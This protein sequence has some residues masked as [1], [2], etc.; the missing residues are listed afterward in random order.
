[1]I[2]S[3]QSLGRSSE[4]HARQYLQQHGLTYVARNYTTATGEIDLI[5]RDGSVL[6]FIEV[7]TRQNKYFGTAQ[8]SVDYRKQSKVIKTAQ[9]YLKQY[10]LTER[11]LCR[12]DVVAV[13][14]SNEQ[15]MIEWIKSAFET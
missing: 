8:D 7:R 4:A 12:F 1:M 13:G 5:M 15:V 11:V 14:Y 6:V 10:Q 3:S 9:C 2:F